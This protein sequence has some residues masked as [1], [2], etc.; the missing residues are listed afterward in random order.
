MSNF[1][2][3]ENNIEIYKTVHYMNFREKKLFCKE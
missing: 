3:R 1:Y 2:Y